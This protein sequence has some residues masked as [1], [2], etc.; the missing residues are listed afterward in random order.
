[1]FEG[2]YI[3][4]QQLFYRLQST[5]EHA[6]ELTVFHAGRNLYQQSNRVEQRIL[7]KSNNGATSQT[8]RDH[9]RSLCGSMAW[10]N[11]PNHLIRK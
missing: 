8:E 6:D 9:L 5:K 3:D 7:S 4:N 1:M 11:G 10:E 2:L